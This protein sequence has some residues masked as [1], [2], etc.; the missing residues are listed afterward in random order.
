MTND[1]QTWR[2]SDLVRKSSIRP[3]ESSLETGWPTGVLLRSLV[4]TGNMDRDVRPWVALVGYGSLIA[5][6]ELSALSDDA[7]DRA[8]P[9]KL[10][11]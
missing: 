6:S 4:F 11:C 8:I 1:L 10:R 9:V 5:P 7:S 2:H 3:N